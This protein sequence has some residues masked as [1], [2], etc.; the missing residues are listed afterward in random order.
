MNNKELL[1]QFEGLSTP[2]IAD[3]C[4]RLKV[5]LRLAPPGV[6]TWL[7]NPHIAG[8]ALPARHYGSVDIF[9][10][11]LSLANP[12][13]V[14][15]VDNQGRL[16]EACIG[17]LIALEARSQGLA[18]IFVWGA[19]RDTDELLQIGLPIFSYAAFP[20][21]PRRLD[22]REPEALI[23]A[24]IGDFWV[25]QADVFLGDSDGVI[26][27]SGAQVEDVLQE[28]LSIWKKERQQAQAV[29]TGTTLREQLHFEQYLQ[30][31]GVEPGYSFRQHL[32][33]LGRAIEE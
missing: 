11:A 4:L 32:R 21:G 6:K 23:S 25:T 22:L 28:A 18:A 24:R 27:V 20:A 1:E 2:L 3:A 12:G 30:R 17:D 13:D 16:A 26:F 8:N 9:L 29:R 5:P 31:R 33:N 7:E 15:V 19:H 14:L 10:E